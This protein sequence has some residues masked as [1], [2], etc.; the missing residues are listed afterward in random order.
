[1]ADIIVCIDIINVPL[2]RKYDYKLLL[3][4]NIFSIIIVV[5]IIIITCATF[6][7]LVIHY[8][9]ITDS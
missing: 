8:G 6:A 1:M 4:K 7:Y 5:N 3:S 2:N 9:S